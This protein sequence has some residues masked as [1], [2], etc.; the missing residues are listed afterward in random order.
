MAFSGRLLNTVRNADRGMACP[1]KSGQLP[2][3]GKAKETGYAL[4]GKG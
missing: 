3:P 4:P 2:K 1:Q